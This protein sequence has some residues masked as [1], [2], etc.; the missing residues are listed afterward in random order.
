MLQVESAQ[1]ESALGTAGQRFQ[2]LGMVMERDDSATARSE[3]AGIRWWPAAWMVGGGLLA[4]LAVRLWPLSQIQ[5]RNLILFSLGG[6]TL[7]LL[8]IWWLIASRAPWRLRL[9]VVAGLAVVCGALAGTFRIRGVTGDLVPI[10]ENRWAGRTALERRVVEPPQAAAADGARA[11]FPQYLGAGRNARIDG[12]PVLATDW[13]RTPPQ[14]LWRQPVGAGW[15]GFAIVGNRAITLEQRGG[16]EVVLCLDLSSGGLLWEHADEARYESS[17]GGEGP[18]TTPTVVDGRVF[19]FGATGILNC[20]TLDQGKLVWQR[21]MAEE[22]PG[23]LPDWGY[24]GSPLVHAGKVIVS[25]GQGD[26][27]SMRAYRVEDGAPVWA[28]GSQAAGYASPMIF[29]PEGVPQVIGFNLR[30]VTAHDPATGEVLWEHPWGGGQPVV[31]QPVPVGSDEL[32]VSSGYGVGAERLRVTR[33]GDGKWL[34]K[35]LWKSIALKAKM[36]SFVEVDGVLIGLDDGIL[37]GVD[38]SNGRRMWKAG[39][40]GHGQLLWCGKRLLVTAESGDLVLL[41]PSGDGPNELAR[42]PVF[43]GK[44]W[45]PPAISGDLLLMRTDREAACLRLPVEDPAD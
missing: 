37:T 33:G 32:I 15:A 7:L 42:F 27:R 5:V 36:A 23:A 39:R 19:T 26:G 1:V 45:N 24:A 17:L 29:A 3:R 40:Y 28:A 20:L 35:R 34:V 6:I 2:I 22:A 12:G 18:R 8:A 11:D 38:A 10:L 44:T 43:D 14:V 4:H 41:E 31:A 16:R 9:A 25:A 30:A 21:R 13:K